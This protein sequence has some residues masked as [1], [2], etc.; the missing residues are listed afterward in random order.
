MR[1]SAGLAGLGFALAAGLPGG[2]AMLERA[3][4]REAA[5]AGATWQ[6]QRG[7]GSQRPD[8]AQPQRGRGGNQA[9]QQRGRGGDQA[10]Q[11]RGQDRQR[12]DQAQPQRG[13][14]QQGRGSEAAPGQQRREQAAPAGQGRGSQAAPGQQGRGSQATPGQQGRG[15]E[16][17][18]G[19]QRR[20]Q[21]GPGAQ[22]RGPEAAPG[23]QGRGPGAAAGAA[24]RRGGRP[25]RQDLERGVAALPPE[26]RG[27][28]GSPR[29]HERLVAG[30]AAYGATRGLDAQRLD[31]RRGGNGVEVLNP[32]GDL[33]FVLDDR[34]AR[35][36]GFW[37]VRRLGDRR[38][39][40]NAPAFCRSGEGHPVWGREWCLDRGFGL[41]SRAGTIWSRGRVDD[42]VFRRDISHERLLR[43]ALLGVLGESV[44]NRLAVHSLG[45]GYAQPLEGQWVAEPGAPRILHVYAGDVVIAELV[46]VNQ[47]HRADVI[48]VLQPL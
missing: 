9:G 2:A 20:E 22:G 35:E 38:P 43:D 45:M 16:S 21:A 48:Y 42:V 26:V 32:A 5:A 47:S 8:Q 11:Q 39:Q 17:V 13:Q 34:R 46:D 10:G 4:V 41:G 23:R 37:E 6:Q 31:V 24:N 30:A 1:I 36:L 12:P 15:R 25:A 27:W 18:P 14:G 44:F 3:E 19:Q 7:Q 33:L 40:G 29:R 28:A